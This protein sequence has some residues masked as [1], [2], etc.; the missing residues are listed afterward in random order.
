MEVLIKLIQRD[1]IVKRNLSVNILYNL[2]CRNYQ[3]KGTIFQISKAVYWNKT[4]A[5]LNTSSF[6]T[7]TSISYIL[8]F[9]TSDKSIQW[10]RCNH[11]KN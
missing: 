6:L 3:N 10:T 4:H 9:S 1:D 2:I 7:F 8:N 5:P 11:S